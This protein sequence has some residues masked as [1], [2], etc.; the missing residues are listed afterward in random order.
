[1]VLLF[2]F[3]AFEFWVMHHHGPT[4][5]G[6]HGDNPPRLPGAF[7]IEDEVRDS[8][9]VLPAEIIPDKPSLRDSTKAGAVAGTE[10]PVQQAPTAAAQAT[11]KTED[12]SAAFT[13]PSRP[14]SGGGEEPSGDSSESTG[15]SEEEE[16]GYGDMR[17]AVLVPYS[18]PGLPLWFDAFTDLAAANKDLVDWIIFCAEVR[19]T[20]SPLSTAPLT[21]LVD[22]LA[23]G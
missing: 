7:P 3:I 16:D 15:S 12:N 11:P 8:A 10:S 14:V 6:R 18:G 19:T 22:S 4:D 9:T 17:I 23:V 21:G 5:H 13:L 2:T 20:H 1:M